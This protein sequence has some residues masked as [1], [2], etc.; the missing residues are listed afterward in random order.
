MNVIMIISS[1]NQD[2]FQNQL[3]GIYTK[4]GWLGQDTK[5]NYFFKKGNTFVQRK[6][7]FRWNHISCSFNWLNQA[8]KLYPQGRENVDSHIHTVYPTY[9]YSFNI[10]SPSNALSE[11]AWE[12]TLATSELE[13][14]SISGKTSKDLKSEQ[15]QKLSHFLCSFYLQSN[16]YGKI[17]QNSLVLH[18]ITL[19]CVCLFATP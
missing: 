2:I 11:V 1:S 18:I 14:Q 15:S 10:Q 13:L 16:Q 7:N 17:I 8:M 3:H 5:L 6:E 12:D 19:S 9:K 4:D